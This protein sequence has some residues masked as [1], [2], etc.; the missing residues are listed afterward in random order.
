MEH[1]V[2]HRVQ[3]HTY[4]TLG[5]CVSL[6]LAAVHQPPLAGDW[7]S[8]ALCLLRGPASS[9]TASPQPTPSPSPARRGFQILKGCP[10]SSLV[11]KGTA[12]SRR[13]LGPGDSSHRSLPHLPLWEFL[14]LGP[15][16]PL[17]QLWGTP[18]LLC[19]RGKASPLPQWPQGIF[20]GSAN[21]PL[22]VGP[23][24]PGLVIWRHQLHS[25]QISATLSL[26]GGLKAFLFC[27]RVTS[28]V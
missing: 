28:R 5:K 18:P 7:A 21:S 26:R 24:A 1:C 19:S 4:R 6:P 16:S 12:V 15:F 23:L 10:S 9:L 8:V 17:A 22:Q 2:Q 11:H 25:Y 20:A 27:P 13:I 14:C 3:R